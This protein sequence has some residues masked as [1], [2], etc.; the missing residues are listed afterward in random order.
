VRASEAA[1]EHAVSLNQLV[2]ELELQTD[3]M[4]LLNEMA[5]M[6]ECSTTIKEACTVV[7]EFVLK[8]FPAVIAG[9]LYTFRA[10]RNLVEVAVSWE[11]SGHAQSFFGP[12]AC[13]A[14]RRGQPHWSHTAA[15]GTICPHLNELRAAMHL[16]IPMMAQGE[17][18]GVLDLGFPV[19]DGEP[20]GLRYTRQRLAVSVAAQIA[21]SLASLQLR[22]KLRSQSI[23]DPLTGLFNRRYMQ[24]SLEK[25][26][27]RAR[28]K[29][30]SLSVLFL[31]IDHFKRY[32]DTFG[33][34]AGDFVL[35]SVAELLSSF[36]RGDDVACRWGGE[37]F[38]VILPEAL[39]E[40]A[41][42]R[43]NSLRSEVK[44]LAL[45]HRGTSLSGV[46][47]SV[48]VASFPEHGFGSEELLRIADRCLYQSKSA[49]RD[50]VTV[51]NPVEV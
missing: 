14:L 43:A 42:A 37:E 8:L 51:A 30:R 48:G 45:Q 11:D 47:L 50:C 44:K 5:S 38:A 27:I 12:D 16:C 22:E 34:E 28:R 39:S 2:K 40:Q 35:R 46:T 20:S 1:R 18:L 41:A 4:T 3:Q 6:L 15:G 7:R 13:W 33:H 25:E 24:E 10:S 36:F 19:V 31:D 26:I 32:N 9:G 23:R 49:G 17:T 29:N 21:H